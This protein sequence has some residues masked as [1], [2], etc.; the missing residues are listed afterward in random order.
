MRTD[1]TIQIVENTGTDLTFYA[2]NSTEYQFANWGSGSDIVVGIRNEGTASRQLIFVTPWYGHAISNFALAD[3][4]HN[5]AA[6][7]TQY[8]SDFDPSL[9]NQRGYGKS[10]GTGGFVHVNLDST[11]ALSIMVFK[12][13]GAV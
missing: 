5:I 11:Q 1:L 8:Y 3:A 12:A 9:F 2:A 7:Q 10:L 4:T 13:R 6:G